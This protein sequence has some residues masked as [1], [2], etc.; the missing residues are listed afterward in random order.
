MASQSHVTTREQMEARI[1]DFERA[2]QANQRPAIEDF[3]HA[4]PQEREPLLRALVH[5]DIAYRLRAGDTIRVEEYL[6]RF[7]ELARNAD[8]VIE[9]IAVEYRHRQHLGEQP[10]TD[11]YLHR[12]PQYRER[13][14][15]TTVPGNTPLLQPDPTGVR[16]PS[17]PE[18]IGRY[19]VG[20]FLARGGMGEVVR[21]LDTDFDR[22]LALKVLQQQF[23]G[24]AALEE[25]FVR[26]AR[27]TGQLQHPGIPPVQELGRLPDGRPYFIMKLVKGHDLH[28]L[29][30]QRVSVLD[31]QSYFLGVFEQVSRTVA[32]AHARGVIHRDLKPGNVMVGK[33]GEVQVM[34]WGLAKVL[35]TDAPRAAPTAEPE[36]PPTVVPNTPLAAGATQGAVGTPTYM[37]PEQARGEDV[38]LRCDVFGLGGILCTIL[39]G[40]P[41]FLGRDVASANT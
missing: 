28:T 7:A 2:W 36:E 3:L 15:Q 19:R 26:E 18:T 5:I 41:P 39:T 35:T 40:K 8:E 33:F 16:G 23:C 29:L 17:L 12:F 13:L 25:R 31:K 6:R 30:H 37:A 24:Q 4:T 32:F 1:E 11:E 9:L 27:L 20:P 38:D 22:P 34:D 21:V 14:L 10:A